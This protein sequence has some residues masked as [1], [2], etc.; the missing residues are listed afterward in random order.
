MDFGLRAVQTATPSL[1]GA[2]GESE[3]KNGRK[4]EEGEEREE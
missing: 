2:R 1:N 4:E 3:K